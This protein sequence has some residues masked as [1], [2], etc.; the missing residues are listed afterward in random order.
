MA[1]AESPILSSHFSAESDAI[2][3]LFSRSRSL[4]RSHSRRDSEA[5]DSLIFAAASASGPHITRNHSGHA[6]HLPL[7]QSPERIKRSD[8]SAAIPDHKPLLYVSGQAPRRLRLQA[9]EQPLEAKEKENIPQLISS[10]HSTDIL[11][12]SVS[13]K[14]ELPS[15]SST[16]ESTSVPL[17]SEQP[18][19]ESGVQVRC[20]ARTRIP[21][22]HGTVFLHLY[23]NNRDNKE[24]LA[25]VIDP[26][27]YSIDSQYTVPPIRSHSLDAIWSDSETQEDRILRGAYVGRLTPETK[28][29]SRPIDQS[30]WPTDVPLPLVR[31]HSECFTGETIG[32][33][34]CDC[35]EQLDEA[36]RLISQPIQILTSSS[37]TIPGRGAV[38]YLRQE[39]RGI[40]LLSKIRAYNLQDVGHDTVT[41]N[42]LLGHKAD[43]RGYDIAAAI[44]RDLGLGSEQG[45]GIRLLTNNPDKVMALEKEGL[46]VLERVPMVPRSWKCQSEAAPSL[47]EGALESRKAG[48]TMIGGDMARGA[49]LNKY[50]RTKILRMGH[51]LP[52]SMVD[53]REMQ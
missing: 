43:E 12:P 27:Q 34:R 50:L 3:D 52:L 25:I 15:A 7:S 51:M 49:D 20:M 35:G 38:I 24:H 31:V 39:G 10:L 32:S 48:V 16:V 53:G 11:L 28:I 26:A 17:S 21:T 18:P 4:K 33:M 14:R 29:A 6:I 37:A 41:A 45:E 46:R 40:G 1:L 30:R 8:D 5:L 2:Q 42:L 9:Q 22:P 36:I 23:H 47:S 13:R 44:L 19:S